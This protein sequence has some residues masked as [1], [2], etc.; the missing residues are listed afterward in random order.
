MQLGNRGL[1]L[2]AEEEGFISCPYYDS[3]GG[4]WTRGF[5]ETSGIGENIGPGSRCITYQEGLDRLRSIFNSHY[6]YAINDLNVPLNQNQFDALASFVWN[7]GPGSMQWNVGRSLRDR[8]YYQASNEMLQYDTAGGVVLSDLVRRRHRERALF[9]TPDGPPP[10][11]PNPLD[12][13]YPDE[14]KTYDE[15][16]KFHKAWQKNKL[17]LLRKN[18]YEAAAHGRLYT[19]KHKHVEKGWN[20]NH[21]LQRYEILK[22]ITK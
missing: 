8:Q 22:K 10:P 14:R 20:V 17:I 18:I 15:Y 7:L 1:H 21:R 12:V 11:P 13:L 2:I 5:G 9:L 6:A 16:K 4:V 3:Y 19:N